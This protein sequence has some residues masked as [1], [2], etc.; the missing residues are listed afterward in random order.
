MATKQSVTEPVADEQTDTGTDEMLALLAEPF[1]REM[2]RY[3]QGKKLTY[4]PVAEVIARMN[5]VLGV[6]GWSSEVINVWREPDYPEWVLAHVRVTATINGVLV[7][8][9]GVGG[10]QVKKLR[11]GNGVVDL[12]DEY[13]GAMSDA[14]KKACQGYGVG[15]ELARTDE[16]LAIEESYTAPAADVTTH[17]ASDE[18]AMA[19]AVSTETWTQF[20]TR[21]GQLSKDEKAA[22]REWWNATYEGYGNPSAKLSTEDMI[23]NALDAIGRIA[24]DV[25]SA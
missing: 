1:P 21:M 7:Q 10:Q 22:L 16:A 14:L 23:L 9:D 5:R 15:L 18:N 20:Q 11:S 13:K 6:N 2:L 24:L 4:V 8:R 17:P 25:A 19:N 12:G 3:H